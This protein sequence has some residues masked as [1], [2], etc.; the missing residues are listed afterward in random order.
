MRHVVQ[1]TVAGCVGSWLLWAA[2]LASAQQPVTVDQALEA[3]AATGKPIVAIVGNNTCPFCTAL[4]KEFQTDSSLRPIAAQF[5]VVWVDQGTDAWTSWVRKFK[6]EA[7][8]IPYVLVARA[9]GQQLWGKELP[10]DTGANNVD[11]FLLGMLAQAGKPITPATSARMLKVLGEAQQAEQA[12]DIEGAVSRLATV[13]GSGSY[14]QAAVEVEKFAAKLTEQAA[15]KVADGEARL[16]DTSKEVEGAVL[17]VETMRLYGRLPG[18]QSTVAPKVAA[19]RRDPRYK[20]TFTQA[21]L[22]DKAQSYVAK[23]QTRQARTAFEQVIAKYPD[24]P[25]AALA[26]ARLAELN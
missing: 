23:K 3:A 15:T 12:G 14:A 22:I 20:L 9:D 11:R 4:K 7:S 19:L 13:V 24:T 2:G 18:V 21:E 8:S 17:I 16:G 1:A 6:E 10:P 25:A 5:I 26:Q